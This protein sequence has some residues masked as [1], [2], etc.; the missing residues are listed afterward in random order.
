MVF[1]DFFVFTLSAF[2]RTPT[3][4]YSTCAATVLK[5]RVSLSVNRETM[6]LQPYLLKPHEML[7]GDKTN[8]YQVGPVHNAP[9]TSVQHI[10]SLCNNK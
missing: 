4:L 8:S 7:Q 9:A 10:A 6:P 3:L 2:P 1:N 5:A